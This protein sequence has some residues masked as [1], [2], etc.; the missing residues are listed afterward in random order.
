MITDGF[1][2]ADGKSLSFALEKDLSKTFL[3]LAVM[4]KAVVCCTPG[5]SRFHLTFC[6]HVESMYRSCLSSSKSS[7]RQ[8]RQEEPESDPPSYRRRCERCQHDSSCSCRSRYLGCRR[9][10]SCKI[11]R[12]CNQSIPIPQE[13]VARSRNMELS[14]TEQTYPLLVCRQDPSFLF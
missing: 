6:V 13:A 11:G 2:P 5:V 3:E 10:S 9:S 1:T 12:C 7:R 8:A 4:C 14:T